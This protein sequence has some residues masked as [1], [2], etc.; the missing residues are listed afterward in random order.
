MIYGEEKSSGIGFP[1]IVIVI[2]IACL[3]GGLVMTTERPSPA[4]VF[5]PTA[6]ISPWGCSY[7][8]HQT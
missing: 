7:A 4:R 1:L 6:G 2:A 3:C 5:V 8:E